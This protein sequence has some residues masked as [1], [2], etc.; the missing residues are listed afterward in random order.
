MKW[1][2]NPAPIR[3]RRVATSRSEGVSNGL[4]GEVKL[5]IFDEVVE[6]DD[7]LPHESGERYFFGLTGGDESLIK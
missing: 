7:E 5:R 1:R 3:R 4:S 2:K 6:E